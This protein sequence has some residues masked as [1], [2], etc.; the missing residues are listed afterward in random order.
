M[1]LK[2]GL[3]RRFLPTEELQGNAMRD[4]DHYQVP[5]SRSPYAY[6]YTYPS[7]EPDPEPEPEPEP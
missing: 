4:L 1:G 5:P 6:P 3:G 7:P 2:N